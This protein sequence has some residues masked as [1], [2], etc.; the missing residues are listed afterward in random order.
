MQSI[1]QYLTPLHKKKNTQNLETEGN[2][3]HVI[4][5]ITKTSVVSAFTTAI[6]HHTRS[7]RGEIKQE[8]EA[9]GI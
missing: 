1:G 5:G 3:H 7:Y 6:P 4:E 9:K 8:E 2:S